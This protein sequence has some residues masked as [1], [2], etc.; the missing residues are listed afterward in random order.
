MAQT[1]TL[2]FRVYSARQ[3][4]P[5]EGASI[6]V[7]AAGTDGNVVIANRTT[8]ESGNTEPLVFTTP[9]KY[10]STSPNGERGYTL[11]DVTITHPM[12]SRVELRD[13]QIFP[14]EES[15]QNMELIPL[16]EFADRNETRFYRGE[17]Q[18]LN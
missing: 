12:Y 3:A 7:T 13:V 15:I 4:I 6:T 9:D 17:P 8:D 14:G 5:I 10:V 2:V 16:S 11:V 18:P 1:G